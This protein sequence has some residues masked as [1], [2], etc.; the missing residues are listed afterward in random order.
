METI[1][2]R[3]YLDQ[4]DFQFA[5]TFL[6]TFLPCLKNFLCALHHMLLN[7]I[8]EKENTNVLF[9]KT[10]GAGFGC[11]GFVFLE[12]RHVVT[13]V[14]ECYIYWFGLYKKTCKSGNLQRQRFFMDTKWQKITRTFVHS[15]PRPPAFE[16]SRLVVPEAFEGRVSNGCRGKIRHRRIQYERRG[17]LVLPQALLA[18]QICEGKNKLKLEALEGELTTN[19][20]ENPVVL[21]CC[22][23]YQYLAKPFLQV[24]KCQPCEN[25]HLT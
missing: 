3:N 17:L 8:K 16:H 10:C 9:K 14:Y 11:C 6:K 24:T 22:L 23:V 21:F 19:A 25:W 15:P 7:I 2:K 20:F 13:F 18:Y 4:L 1:N 5:G 12:Y